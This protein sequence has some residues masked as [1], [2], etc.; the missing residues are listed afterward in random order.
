[1][2]VNY[3]RPFDAHLGCNFTHVNIQALCDP[4]A[5]P[6]GRTAGAQVPGVCVWN[7]QIEDRRFCHLAAID[8]PTR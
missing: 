4:R 2:W 8:S 7:F 3:T 5:P 6:G 1:V